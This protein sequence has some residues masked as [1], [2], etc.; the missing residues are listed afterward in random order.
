M[1]R[2]CLVAFTFG[3]TLS[4]LACFC[5]AQPGPGPRG[6][7]FDEIRKKYDKDGDGRLSEAERQALQEDVRSGRIARPD[8]QGNPRMLFDRLDQDGDGRV[9]RKEVPERARSL[10]ERVDANGDGTV[11]REEFESFHPG[12]RPEMPR[13]GG[14]RPNLDRLRQQME[15]ELDIP[16]AAT[17]NPRQR[18]DLMLPKQRSGD[19]LLPVIVFIHGGG[20]QNGDKRGG[21][22]RLAPLVTGGEYAGVSVGYRLTDEAS[23]PAQIHDCKA[24]IRWIRANAKKYRLD[25]DRIGV[26]GTSAGGHLVAMLGTSGDVAELEGDLGEHTGTSSRVQCVVDFFGPSDFLSMGDR[27]SRINHNAP[28]SPEGKLLGGPVQERKEV[29][30]SASP[31]SYVTKDD[32]PFLILHGTEDNVVPYQQSVR[33]T[34]MLKGAGVDATL[35]TVEGGG[36]GFPDAEPLERVRAFLA[37]ELRSQKVEVSGAAIQVEGGRAR[38][39]DR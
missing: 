3:L 24:A 38:A 9:D 36:H 34:D 1:A 30:R 39:G 10:F 26:W 29:A 7:Q 8:G 18:L 35:V 37:R 25:P 21:L 2:G 20:W 32:P 28:N 13:A 14:G 22:G 12:E 4:L 33:L 15:L 19:E 16:Y 11:T 31:V 27:P 23:W 17:D 5:W 6:P